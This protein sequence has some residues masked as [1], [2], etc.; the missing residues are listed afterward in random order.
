MQEGTTKTRM[1]LIYGALT[2]ALEAFA[3]VLFLSTARV[4][5]EI[6]ETCGYEM[7]ATTKAPIAALSTSSHVSLC[8]NA[9]SS[10]RTAQ[11][12]TQND[13][14]GIGTPA[15][16]ARRSDSLLNS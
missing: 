11:A 7:Q 14:A 4:F 8:N 6:R 13:C 9:M 15:G 12:T 5:R 1:S 16:K 10:R 3:H 2:E